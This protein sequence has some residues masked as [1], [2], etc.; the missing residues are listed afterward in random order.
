M[1]AKD[2]IKEKLTFLAQA[3]PHILIKYEFNELIKT[4]VVELSPIESYYK[5]PVL[6]DAWIDISS[7]FQ[8]RFPSEDISFV[9]VDSTLKIN[10]PEFTFNNEIS[11]ITLKPIQVSNLYQA[12]SE[13][14]EEWSTKINWEKISIPTDITF[15][16]NKESLFD[17][18]SNYAFTGKPHLDLSDLN[19]TPDYILP[20]TI[21][22]SNQTISVDESSY[23]MAA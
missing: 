21:S 13:I 11:R 7:K 4:H 15:Y 14:Y 18:V 5:D 19:I 10:N 17:S 8:E 12:V 6:D 22:I 1:L 20:T 2:F 3:F 23:A 9:S 16:Y